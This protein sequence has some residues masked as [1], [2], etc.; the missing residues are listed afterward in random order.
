MQNFISYFI[1]ALLALGP[2]AL[3]AYED[4]RTLPFFTEERFRLK[5]NTSYYYTEDNFTGLFRSESLG[6]S[7]QLKGGFPPFFHFMRT[8]LS[9]GYT[10]FSH[11]SAEVF[12]EGFW[13]AQSGNGTAL[14]FSSP[15]V[16]RVG[17]VLR[18]HYLIEGVFGFIPEISFSYPLF[19]IN[20][21]TQTA[22]T[23]DGV[24]R[25]T[26]SLWLYGVLFDTVIPF[27]QGGFKWRGH[28]LSSFFQ[29]KA[30][31]M[32]RADIAEIGFYTRGFWSVI[33]DPSSPNLGDRVHLLK[34][35]NAGSLRFFSSNPNVIGGTGWLAWHFPFLTL[36]FSGDMDWAGARYSKGYGVL[37]EIII[38]IGKIHK[39]RVESLFE[40]QEAGFEPNRAKDSALL[41][42]SFN[43]NQ[44]K[45]NRVDEEDID[46][47][48]N[49]SEYI[50]EQK[51]QD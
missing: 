17:G 34:K 50:E 10:A 44:E 38:K 8:G 35:V 28:P 48:F 11:L 2:L 18:S 13:F 37:A 41:E 40:G 19:P 16:K 42:Q 15:E 14:Y 4:S 45:V 3:S 30:G 25:L 20:Y 1:L 23:D 33:L 7:L 27:V 36:R 51:I 32:L 12:L 26:P 22:I 6:Q 39:T 49:E 5:M 9:L 46:S 24:Y 29:W 43:K 47:L 21:N 31:L